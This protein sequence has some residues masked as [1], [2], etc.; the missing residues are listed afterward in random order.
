[1][2]PLTTIRE[3]IAAWL[4]ADLLEAAERLGAYQAWRS[5]LGFEPKLDVDDDEIVAFRGRFP[6]VVLE[7]DFVA[8]QLAEEVGR[9]L[10]EQFGLPIY[11]RFTTNALDLISDAYEAAEGN[12]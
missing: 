7:A 11:T 10:R 4:E 1:M 2:D 6:D 8:A 9:A 5:R 3:A 12:P